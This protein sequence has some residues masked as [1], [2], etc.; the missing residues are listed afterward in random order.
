VLSIARFVSNVAYRFAAPFLAIIATGLGVSMGQIG[1]AI[2]ASEL[3]ALSAP[4]IG[5]VVDGVARRT[6]MLVG[7]AVVA[8]GALL[9]L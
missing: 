8:L 2:A 4:V 7:L 5:R 6:A 1:V 3:V 9:V